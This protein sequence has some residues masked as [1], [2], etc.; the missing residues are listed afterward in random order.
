VQALPRAEEVDLDRI[1]LGEPHI[2]ALLKV[3]PLT[4]PRTLVCRAEHLDRRHHTL[5]RLHVDDLD[6][7]FS[8]LHRSDVDQHRI[9]DGHPARL[10][11]VD[12]L[13]GH[14][15]SPRILEDPNLR[16]VLVPTVLGQ[17]DVDSLLHPSPQMAW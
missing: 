5:A 16:V 7:A 8:P 9:G 12:R 1:D 15:S 13:S 17:L 11:A 14:R 10:L 6:V 2:L 4:F 3:K